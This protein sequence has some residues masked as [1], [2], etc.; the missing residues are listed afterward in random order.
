[1]ATTERVFNSKLWSEKFP[2]LTSSRAFRN[3]HEIQKLA[4]ASSFQF[5]LCHYVRL[6]TF[7][8]VVQQKQ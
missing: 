7:I 5:M 4:K 8:S 3:F 6:I 1:M 2:L